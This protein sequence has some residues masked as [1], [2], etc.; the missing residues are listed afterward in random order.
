[1]LFSLIKCHVEAS[2]VT[3]HVVFPHKMSR[4]RFHGYI[5]FRSPS[6]YLPWIPLKLRFM[7]FSLI[8]C[9]VDASKV[10]FHV[11]F[12]HKMSR[13]RLQGYTSW[14]IPTKMSHRNPQAYLPGSSF[15]VNVT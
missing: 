3:F 15:L 7:L 4:G 9:H 13:R 1:M 10:T 12:P 8:K 2:K 5:S 11:V 14:C 6:Y